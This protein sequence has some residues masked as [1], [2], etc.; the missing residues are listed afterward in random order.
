MA[1]LGT[2]G[3]NQDTE[4]QTAGSRTQQALPGGK[5]CTDSGSVLAIAVA[6]PATVSDIRV[7][8][9]S[10]SN[11]TAANRPHQGNAEKRPSKFIQRRWDRHCYYQGQDRG[12]KENSLNRTQGGVVKVPRAGREKGKGIKM[13]SPAP[14]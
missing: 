9:W 3:K 7:S 6:S 10:G 11:Q 2:D 14:F 12:E 13:N 4:E 5:S 1:G 8:P